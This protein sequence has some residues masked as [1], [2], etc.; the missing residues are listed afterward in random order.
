MEMNLPA[1]N[2]ETEVLA[3]K[4]RSTE[5][6]DNQPIRLG[7]L[8]KNK[9][10][11]EQKSNEDNENPP[12]HSELPENTVKVLPKPLPP[13]EM[14]EIKNDPPISPFAGNKKLKRLMEKNKKYV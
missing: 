5:S 11:Q 2:S 1:R 6:E 3:K 10:E 4:P 7:N 8:D 12:E 9:D 13:A 14:F